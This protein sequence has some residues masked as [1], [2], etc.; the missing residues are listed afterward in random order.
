MS[1]RRK[2]G[3]EDLWDPQ[4]TKSGAGKATAGIAELGMALG[5]WI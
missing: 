4:E 5:Y 1:E 3:E 2:A